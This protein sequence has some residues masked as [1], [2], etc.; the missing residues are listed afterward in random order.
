[1]IGVLIVED[2][3]RVARLHAEIVELV[4]GLRVLG[5]VHTASAALEAISRRQPELLLLDLFLPDASGLALLARIRS[6]PEPPDVIV[7]SAANDMA[8]VRTAM[9]R[10]AL[11]YLVKPFDIETL[12]ERLRQYV[13]LH[14]RRAREGPAGQEQ[15]DELFGAMRGEESQPAVQLP[16]GHSAATAKLVLGALAEAGCPLSAGELAERV[17]ISRATAQRYLSSLA[18]AGSVKLGL[19]YGATGRPEHRYELLR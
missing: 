1:V 7:L 5:Q 11:S 6:L 10:G 16:K 9:R 18:E 8:S 3:F 15:I 14:A 12:R 19:R 4:A 2:D 13:E 17:G